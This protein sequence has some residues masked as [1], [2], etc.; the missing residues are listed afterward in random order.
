MSEARLLETEIQRVLNHAPDLA[1]AI[2]CGEIETVY[3]PQF[4]LPEERLIGAEALARWKH[5]ELGEIGAG[6]LFAIAEV[7]GVTSRLSHRIVANALA[8][9]ARW[10]GDLR[11]SVNVLPEEMAATGF[12]E[13]FLL[14]VSQAGINPARLTVEITEEVLLGDLPKAAVTLGTLREAGIRIALDDFGAGFCNFRYLK[15]LPL[16]YLKLDRSMVDGIATDERDLAV[17]R[18]I[19][20]MGRAL[21]LRVIA[22]GIETEAQRDIV[23]AEGC[24]TYQGFLRAAPMPARTFR[25]LAQA[26]AAF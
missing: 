14:R 2:E 15:I 25:E 7:Q 22:E 17:L 24:D 16:D 9:F 10:P 5:P 3:Q 1:S 11:L 18:G 4:V 19:V 23:A 26:Q 12:A 6:P 13:G 21:G 8:E 20:A